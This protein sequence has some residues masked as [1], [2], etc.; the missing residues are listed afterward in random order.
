MKKLLIAAAICG[1]FFVPVKVLAHYVPDAVCDNG[2]HV[3]NPHC[4]PKGTY[5]TP[6]A[7]P[8][9]TPTSSDN[10]SGSLLPSPTLVVTSPS[11]TLHENHLRTDLSD[12]RSDGHTESLGCLHPSDHCYK[13][14]G[15]SAV[16]SSHTS[17]PSTG[18]NDYLVIVGLIGIVMFTIGLILSRISEKCE[19]CGS[20]LRNYD[21]EGSQACCENCGFMINY[22]YEERK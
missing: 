10:P 13:E 7:S 15:N 19:R 4:T 18:Q 12:G 17:L 3:G 9:A 14:A 11:D 22:K 21:S 1:L 6:T 2:E 5:A 16:L 20:P 8:T